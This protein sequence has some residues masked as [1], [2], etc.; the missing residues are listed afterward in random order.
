VAIH[1]LTIAQLALLLAVA[2]GAPVIAAKIL[3]PRLACPLDDGVAFFDGQPLLGKS[4]TVRGIVVSILFSAMA[5]PLLGLGWKI[6]LAVGSAAMAG[7][8]LSSFVK[9]RLRLASSNRATGL[10]QIPE[11]LFPLLACRG[12]LALS[13]LD[14]ALGVAI[15]FAGEVVLSLLLYK[16]HIRDRPY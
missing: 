8:L 16:A 11:S 2:N 14:I 10:D 13:W 7:D 5:A 3:G 6:G 4:K 1:F 12:A 9:R 15:F